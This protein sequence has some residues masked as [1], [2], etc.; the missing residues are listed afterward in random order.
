MLVRNRFFL[1]SLFLGCSPVSGG[2]EVT[3]S[4]KLGP[5][6]CTSQGVVTVNNLGAAPL[7]VTS[8]SKQSGAGVQVPGFLDEHDHP[9]LLVV[10]AQLAPGPTELAASFT[11]PMDGTVDEL[12]VVLELNAGGH[13]VPLTLH[14]TR[15]GSALTALE[16]LDVGVL[17]L[18]ATS[19]RPLAIPAGT[20]ATLDPPATALTLTGA[21]LRF[22][23]T[24]ERTSVT[25]LVLNRD[26]ETVSSVVVATGVPALLTVQ[27]PQLAFG[28]VPA[29]LSKTKRL[30]V[31]NHALAPA[32]VTAT[33]QAPFDVVAPDGGA[34]VLPAATRDSNDALVPTTAAL[35]VR[36]TPA[37]A[38]AQGTLTLSTSV[39]SQPTLV[40]PLSGKLGGPEVEVSP[41]SLTFGPGVTTAMVR[42]RNVAARM[43][44]ADPAANL[45]LGIDGQAPYFELVHLSGT[46]GNVTVALGAGYDRNNGIAPNTE[47]TL[48][49]TASPGPSEDELRLF[50]DDLDEPVT[51]VRIV[52]P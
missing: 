33:T 16:R 24:E 13:V 40:V 26:C 43:L 18:G 47:L 27:P 17:P 32:T 37:N 29:T 22:S 38:N 28:Y 36:F 9:F 14:G 35:D 23:P 1:L 39:V 21:D 49:V 44:P 19:T 48:A 50:T 12:E 51:I 45:H 11:A 34:L 41:P 2:L 8:V 42:I 6:R 20:T 5:T 3:A 31:F 30:T 25:R 10:P 46:A 52:V 15:G 7:S 4:P